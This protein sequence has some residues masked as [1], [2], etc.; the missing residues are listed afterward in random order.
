MSQPDV[1]AMIDQP[2]SGEQGVY[3]NQLA[4]GT[5]LDIETQHHHYRLVKRADTHVRISG[6]PMLCPEP[7]EVE[8][9][10][11]LAGGPQPQPNPGYIG[12]GMRLVFKDPR[13]DQLIT[14]SRI[15]K[16]HKLG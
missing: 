7:I 2:P 13:F 8:L 3:L 5:V 15:R 11:S 9:E 1:E 10:G 4:E 14:T 16:I 6:H 12:R